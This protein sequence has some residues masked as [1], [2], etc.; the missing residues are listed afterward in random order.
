MCT[1]KCLPP[2]KGGP[3]LPRSDAQASAR[4]EKLAVSIP[5]PKP[6]IWTVLS[7]SAIEH[8]AHKKKNVCMPPEQKASVQ[9]SSFVPGVN[10]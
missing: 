8:A 10:A 5:K 4:V 6:K 3:R 1:S 9:N 2:G 7:A